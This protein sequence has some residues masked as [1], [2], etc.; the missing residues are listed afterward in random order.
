MSRRILVADDDSL[1]CKLLQ[2]TV[3]QTGFDWEI[4]AA[5]SGR[6][7]L[8]AMEKQEP[9]LLLL[10]LRMADGDGYSVLEDRRSK[11]KNYPV[12][13]VTHLASDEHEQRCLELGARSLVKKV[14]MRIGDMV[15]VIEREL[16]AA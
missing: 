15:E 4:V 6:E 8:M 12:V 10:D 3:E 2:Y 16:S 1:F 7:A 9:D 13:V 11:G 5:S 14:H